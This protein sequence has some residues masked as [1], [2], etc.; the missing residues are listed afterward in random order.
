MSAILLGSHP[1]K[2][3]AVAD[4]TELIRISAWTHNEINTLEGAV[5]RKTAENFNRSQHR[6][7]V[8]FLASMAHHYQLRVQ[9]AAAA[10]SLPC[11]LDLDGPD[12]AAFAWPGYLRPID[13]FVSR[14]M[15]NDFLPSILAQGTFEGRLYSLGQYDSGL[16]LWGNRRYL[17]AAGV[18]IPTL[19]APWSMTE[20]EQAL[21]K[22]TALDEVDYALTLN[23]HA[24][25]EFLTYAYSPLLQGF[26]GD[27]IDRKPPGLAKGTLDGPQSVSA[28]KR[29]R[30]WVDKGWSLAAVDRPDDFNK[31][32][33]A[34]SWIGHWMY[35]SYRKD[36]GKDLVL[37]PLP[38]FGQGIKTG[39]GSWN[40]GITSTCRHP[41]AAWAFLAYLL[42]NSEI[43]R[44]TTANGAVPARRS[45]LARSALYRA[46][47]P[48][49]LFAQQLK[50]GY[51]V[52][53]PLT[54]AYG[55]IRIAFSRAVKSITGGADVQAELGKAA[56][57]IDRDG[58]EYR[59]DPIR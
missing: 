42:S 40:W 39:M 16:A 23:L 45:A 25:E 30:H 3:A 9:A 20:F 36:L 21:D 54:P 11:V 17:R 7:R 52:P 28:M 56:A 47:G 46:G 8:E 22:L 13:R 26:G 24:G 43:L 48:L 19:Q 4:T 37:L 1:G 57:S 33:V 10:G 51:G 49:N 2:S 12:L 34:L 31:G 14:Q 35:R 6:Y 53:R 27:L 59:G 38:D 15:R 58:A 18:R 44:M 50:G 32:R 41:D 29:L 5:L 55:V